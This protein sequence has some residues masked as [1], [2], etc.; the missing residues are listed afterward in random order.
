MMIH[1]QN[2]LDKL[3]KWFKKMQ[4][5]FHCINSICLQTGHRCMD[6]NYNMGCTVLGTTAKEKD[7]GITISADTKM[8]QSNVVL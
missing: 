2:D 8:F 7:I 6:I 3:V 5:L 4:M 1:L